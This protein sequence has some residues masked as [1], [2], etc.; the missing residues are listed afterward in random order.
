MISEY[1]TLAGRNIFKKGIRSWLTMMGI[2]IGIA[3][4][5]SLISLGQGMKDAIETQFSKMGADTIIVMPGAGFESF[6]SAKLT[7]H[8]EDVVTSVRGVYKL[9]PFA[10]KL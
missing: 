1:F 8:D 10:V 3:A 5:V 6:G 9:A 2:F 7:K 4:V